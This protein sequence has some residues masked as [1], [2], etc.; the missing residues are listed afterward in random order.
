[1]ARHTE[2]TV[3]EAGP[4]DNTVPAVAEPTLEERIQQLEGVIKNQNKQIKEKD[5]K[6][7][8]LQAQLYLL[9]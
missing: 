6:I 5:E 4:V 8:S 7:A 9:P 1:M 3:Q 2:Q